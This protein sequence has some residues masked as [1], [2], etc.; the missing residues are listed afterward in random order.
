MRGLWGHFNMRRSNGKRSERHLAR[1]SS[2]LC[3]PSL[4]SKLAIVA[5]A[6]VILVGSPILKLRASPPESSADEMAARVIDAAVE[7]FSGPD[8]GPKW[9]VLDARLGRLLSNQTRQADEAVVILESFYLGEHNGEELHENIL[10]R[11]PRMIPLL[12]Q[13]LH[14]EPTSLLKRYPGRMKLERS[15]TVMY[16]KEDIEILM[17]QGGAR[18]VAGLSI[19]TAPL[20][21]QSGACAPKLLRHPELKPGEILVQPGESYA[22]PPVLRA[23]I[24]EDGKVMNLQLLSSS[25]IR[26]LDAIL[27]ANGKQWKYAPRPH[28]GSVPA[29]IVVTVGWVPLK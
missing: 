22:G 9:D 20:S 12:K 24:E 6:L 5:T 7:A 21:D 17:V 1:W 10:S 26:R 14:K 27:S 19:E 2:A 11:G 4:Q 25:G 16:L 8:W 18:R 13:Y 15:T 29:N 28:C 3:F 23:D